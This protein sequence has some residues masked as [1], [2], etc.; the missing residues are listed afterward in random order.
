MG[1]SAR[2]HILVVDD[3][4]NVCRFAARVLEDAGYEVTR[5]ADGAEALTLIQ[6]QAACFA[7]VV[8]D[9]AMPRMNGVKLLERL[10]VA[11]PDLPVVLMSGYATEQLQQRGIA[12]PCALLA[13]PFTPEA[14]LAEVQRCL[15]GRSPKKP[16]PSAA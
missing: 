15:D 6:E 12:A 11:V 16:A 5:A 14:L 9:V 1:E 8:S 4:P 13:K 7:A 2:L 10:S 3:E